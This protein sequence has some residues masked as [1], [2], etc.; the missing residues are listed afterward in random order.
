M[1]REPKPMVKRS[2]AALRAGWLVA[3]VA[4]GA[5]ITIAG[6][7]LGLG[8][9]DGYYDRVVG[10]LVGVGLLLT[11]VAAWMAVPRPASAARSVGEIRALEDSSTPVKAI[12]LLVR[13]LVI[14][15]LALLALSI[16]TRAG[17]VHS[18]LEPP[19]LR[20]GILMLVVVLASSLAFVQSRT[21]RRP[22]ERASTTTARVVQAS[23]IT[24][25]LACAAVAAWLA[26]QVDFNETVYGGVQGQDFPFFVLAAEVA[27][28]LAMAASGSLPSLAS[29]VGSD[30]RATAHGMRGKRN[31]V[32]LPVLI[33]FVLLFLVFLLILLFG[34]GVVGALDQI[35]NTP[36]LLATLGILVVALVAALVAAFRLAKAEAKPEPL[37]KKLVDAKKRRERIIIGVS[38]A[39]ALLLLV[40][41]FLLFEGR[42]FFDFSPDAWVHFLCLGLLVGLGPYGF[43][44]AN[45]SHRVRLLEERFPDF[46]R[47]VASS[48][49]G[50]LTLAQSVAVA[51]RGEYG[52]LSPEVQRMADQLSWNVPFNEALERF[53]GR[54]Q[55]PLVQRAVSLILEA[56][57]SGGATTDVLLA[58]ARD[59]R[60]I[61][62][63]EQ[64][65]R[66]NM[67]LY[68]VVIYVTFFVF[69]GVTAVLYSQFVPQLV[70][71]SHAAQEASIAAG[72]AQIAGVN[73][74]S[75][76]LRDFQLFYFMAALMQGLG[77]G[78]VAGM[79]GSGK[80]VLGLRHSFIMVALSYVTFVFLIK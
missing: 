66:I 64:D 19:A 25:V 77:D 58:A 59:A 18:F 78:I 48:H 26:I 22:A 50:G 21:L 11:A 30:K 41:A 72:G 46:L 63:L 12:S 36:Y 74:A 10:A 24:L 5:V 49:K 57:R 33:A 61:K 71:S 80:A 43:Y 68:T 27:A 53:G 28:A 75:L 7:A 2:R 31:V 20:R 16:L 67:S 47:D 37:Y 13:L 14:M 6:A 60:E 55:T 23:F 4:S 52:P 17:I 40:P 9:A 62:F 51:A 69:L 3:L 45:E 54:V 65:R 8:V 44:M 35:V 73:T 15:A 42:S 29:L 79:M 56:N 1:A 70:A 76:D 38:I 39:G 32:F 34:V